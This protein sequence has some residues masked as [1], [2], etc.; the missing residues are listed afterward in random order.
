MQETRRKV[1]H[2]E[3]EDQSRS[4]SI[5]RLVLCTYLKPKIPTNK[6]FLP[7]CTFRQFFERRTQTAAR[8][9]FQYRAHAVFR[10]PLMLVSLPAIFRVDG[11]KFLSHDL[12]ATKLSRRHRRRSIRA[13]KGTFDST[14]PTFDK[15]S[16]RS[17][18]VIESVP[19]ELS[20]PF[21]L[22]GTVRI[23]RSSTKDSFVSYLEFDQLSR[24]RPAPIFVRKRYSDANA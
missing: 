2:L 9:L 22:S 3:I 12:D 6:L 8:E 19:G 23:E 4:R 11:K 13:T 15:R 16:R 5:S 20:S 14:W 21:F 18:L 10:R 24:G 1:F 7:P 17:N